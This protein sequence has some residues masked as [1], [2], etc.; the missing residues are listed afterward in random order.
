MKLSY[1]KLIIFKKNWTVKKF[2]VSKLS[3]L[4]LSYIPTDWFHL[5]ICPIIVW[6]FHFF[7]SFFTYFD[8]LTI[9]LLSFF[10][11]LFRFFL[12]LFVPSI[13][14]FQ[15]FSI[16]N[17]F[18]FISHH[19]ILC[20]YARVFTWRL[21]VDWLRKSLCSLWLL[22]SASILGKNNMRLIN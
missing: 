5:F 16:S 21:R 12:C 6:L 3:N 7:P 18:H 14:L 19:S 2:F 10:L 17:F 1:N 15:L 13:I 4:F 11:H 20:I 8:C 22:L 9:P